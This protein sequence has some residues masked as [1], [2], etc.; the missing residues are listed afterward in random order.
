M[1][2]TRITTTVAIGA[3]TN[4]PSTLQYCMTGYWHDNDICLAVRL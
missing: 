2:T 1:T 4:Q 3:N